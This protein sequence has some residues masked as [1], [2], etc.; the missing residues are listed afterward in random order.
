MNPDI[1]GVALLYW[2]VKIMC[3]GNNGIII[4]QPSCADGHRLWTVVLELHQQLT[5]TYHLM[6]V[7][8]SSRKILAFS[9]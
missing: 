6:S 1:N 2:T 7:S 3:C 4:D 5:D 9:P 8:Q